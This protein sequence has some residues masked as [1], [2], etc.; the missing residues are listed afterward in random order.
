MLPTLET[1]LTVAERRE[2][3]DGGGVALVAGPDFASTGPML[4]A[5][6]DVVD[7]S[8]AWRF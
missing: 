5:G 6:M 1:G 2:G 4:D 7:L 8:A 3:C